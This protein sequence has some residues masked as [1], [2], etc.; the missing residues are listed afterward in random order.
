MGAADIANTLKNPS[1]ILEFFVPVKTII[2]EIEVD[3]TRVETIDYQ[4]LVTNRPVETGLNISDARIEQ[5]FAVTLD[6]VITNDE[7]ELSVGS[8]LSLLDGLDTWEDKRDKLFELKDKNKVID[9][10]SGFYQYSDMLIK[11]TRFDRNKDTADAL[12]FQ[13]ELIHVRLVASAISD[14]DFSQIPDSLLKKATG[15]NRD[16]AKAAAKKQKQ[17]NKTAPDADEKQSSILLG[18]LRSLGFSV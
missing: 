17:G 18:G 8:V 15:A 1:S 2:D 7:V 5:P 4:W 12:F 9:V 14:V 6:C 16:A 3:V 11:A 13:I 10:S